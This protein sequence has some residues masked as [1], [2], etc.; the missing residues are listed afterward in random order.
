MRWHSNPASMQRCLRLAF[1]RPCHRKKGGLP[2][3]SQKCLQCNDEMPA[4]QCFALQYANNDDKHTS[5]HAW[6]AKTSSNPADKRTHAHTYPHAM[7]ADNSCSPLP[8]PF[9]F[10]HNFGSKFSNLDLVHFPLSHFRPH[11]QQQ[12]TNQEQNLL[13][14]THKPANH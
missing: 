14:F 12:P 2:Q 9:V 3:H 6:P 11:N 8:L 5:S 10:S 13:A 4:R 1:V 7:A